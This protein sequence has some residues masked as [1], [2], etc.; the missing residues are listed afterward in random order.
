MP[1]YSSRSPVW[2]LKQAPC[3]GHRT[4]WPVIAPKYTPHTNTHL[5]VDKLWFK[6]GLCVPFYL[7]WAAHRSVCTDYQ[8]RWIYPHSVSGACCDF[9]LQLPSSFGDTHVLM[10]QSGWTLWHKKKCMHSKATGRGWQPEARG[11]HMV[12]YT[13]SDTLL[14]RFSTFDVTFVVLYDAE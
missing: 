11:P 7:C 6:F 14:L 10:R 4:V 2:T 3:H 9:P 5:C 1:G 12:R 8:W 13:I